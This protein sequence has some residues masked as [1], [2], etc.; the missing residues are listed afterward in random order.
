MPGQKH[1]LIV[2]LI[3]KEPRVIAALLRGSDAAVPAF[4]KVGIISPDLSAA[5]PSSF[6]A[7][8]SVLF[9]HRGRK[10]L[11]VV[12]EIQLKWDPDKQWVWPEY[13]SRTRADY[14]VPTVL[15]VIVVSRH[16]AARL[17]RGFLLDN[18]TRFWM[19]SGRCT[20]G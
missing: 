13:Q 5:R 10:R 8:V 19:C 2:D 6:H 20:S 1:E 9:R 16:L 7:D 15:L 17:S 4:T 14:R 12:T 3:K 18:V 11:A